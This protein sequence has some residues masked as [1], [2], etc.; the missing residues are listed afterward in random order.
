MK[1]KNY[2]YDPKTFIVSKEKHEVALLPDVGRYCKCGCGHRIEGRRVTQK[3]HGQTIS[4]YLKPK[5]NQQ[6]ATQHCKKK[7]YNHPGM[8]VSKA[9][10]L[11]G[12]KL[13][14][15]HDGKPFRVASLYLK[16][17]LKRE[18]KIRE[19]SD[20]W[21]FLDSLDKNRNKANP[22]EE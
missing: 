21:K 4:Y 10:I 1:N 3:L 6:W 2:G 22:K 20:L 15:D 19:G 18:F 14:T 7:Y 5:K 11:C 12:I 16:A 17:G 9:S 13:K 8:H